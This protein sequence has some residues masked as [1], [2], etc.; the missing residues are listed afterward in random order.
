ME[1]KYLY[2]IQTAM[3]SKYESLP[4]IQVDNSL[5]LNISIPLWNITSAH[6]GLFDSTYKSAR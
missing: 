2:L 3:I 1:N 6:K 4:P 5:S